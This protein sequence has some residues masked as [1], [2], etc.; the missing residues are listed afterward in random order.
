MIGARVLIA[1]IGGERLAFDVVSVHEVLDAPEVAPLPLMPRGIAGQMPHRGGY[2]PVLDPETVLGV[3]R[4][5]GTGAA[6]VL[7]QVPAALWIDDAEEVWEL[8]ETT[9]Q[10][11]PAG[12]DALGVLRGL[13]LR[14]RTVVA[15]VDAGA[16]ASSALATLRK[17]INP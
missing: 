17:G 4:A 13:L 15:H 5:G 16:L 11:V 9:P 8:A 6:L 12:R 7:A 14:Q 1:R 3:A 2:L 10:G